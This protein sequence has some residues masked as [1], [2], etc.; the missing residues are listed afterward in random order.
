MRAPTRYG[1]LLSRTKSDLEGVRARLE[2]LSTPEP[3]TGCL[4]W[5]GAATK[6]GYGK[7]GLG[8]VEGAPKF[9]AYAHRVA[10]ELENGPIPAGKTVDH[11]C[12][13]RG[14][15]NPAHMEAVT[16][17]Q[18]CARRPKALASAAAVRAWATRRENA[19]RAA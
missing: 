6:D 15:I 12:R 10:F 4:L 11:K 2:R 8:P 13:Q 5:V 3:N 18:N 14:C 1:L 16:H 9:V 17:Q 7:V 19:R